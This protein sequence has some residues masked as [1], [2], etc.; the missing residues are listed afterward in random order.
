[1]LQSINE[2][3]DKA[4]RHAMASAKWMPK[5]AQQIVDEW[6]RTVRHSLKDLSK[7][8]NKSFDLVSKYLARVQAEAAPKEK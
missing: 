3:S 1:M 4:I 6:Q 2:R 8:V 5:E 7:S